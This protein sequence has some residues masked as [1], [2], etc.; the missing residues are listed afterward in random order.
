MSVEVQRAMVLEL[1][2][3]IALGEGDDGR[4]VKYFVNDR[5]NVYDIFILQKKLTKVNVV[6]EHY[7]GRSFGKDW[8][9]YL[10]IPG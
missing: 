2:G 4:A 5:G 3:F 7:K 8:V 9:L 6:E 10:F 1:F